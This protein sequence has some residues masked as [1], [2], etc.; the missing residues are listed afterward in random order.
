MAKFDNI[1]EHMEVL[2][3]DGQ[4]VGTVDHLEGA[5]KVEADQVGF[6]R[7]QASSHFVR[8]HRQGGSENTPEESGEG[9]EGRLANGSLVLVRKWGN[10]AKA[11]FSFLAS[12]MRQVLD[13]RH[14]SRSRQQTLAAR[15]TSAQK[16]RAP[17]K[18]IAAM[19][20]R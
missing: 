8:S 2:G 20:R 11:G 17:A 18:N 7:R 15:R 14:D 1:R 10:P 6:R 19:F 5:D 4:H 9:R 13:C 16:S 12:G 3:S